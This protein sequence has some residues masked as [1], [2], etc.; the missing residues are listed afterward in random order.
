MID[1]IVNKFTRNKRD[2]FVNK[3][4]I[5][6]IYLLEPIV[7][8][9]KNIQLIRILSLIKFEPIVTD[10]SK[11]TIKLHKLLFRD[12]IAFREL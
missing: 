11:S 4:V 2:I 10:L 12:S 3:M 7:Q 6:L 8:N 9:Q 1:C 5:K